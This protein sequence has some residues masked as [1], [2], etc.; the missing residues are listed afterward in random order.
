MTKKTSIFS[1]FHKSWRQ[2]SWQLWR[3]HWLDV[4]VLMV[5]ITVISGLLLMRSQRQTEWVTVQLK[6]APEEW[7]YRGMKSDYWLAQNLLPGTIG[8]NSFG[9][10]VAEVVSV[11]IFDVGEAKNQIQVWAKLKVSFDS[12][13]QNYIFGFQPLQIG[14]GLEL[15]FGSQQIKGVVV[16]LDQTSVTRMMKTVKLQV[17]SVNPYVASTYL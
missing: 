11:E 6:V 1:N 9:E 13:K 4:I 15:N 17:F 7:W 14:R 10:A 16:N 2:S 8:T 3:R 12:K 5:I